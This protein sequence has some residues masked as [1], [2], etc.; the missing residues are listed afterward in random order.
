[1]IQW[2]NTIY[3]YIPIH[4]IH[5]WAIWDVIYVTFF[6]DN[7]H[8]GPNIKWSPIPKEIWANITQN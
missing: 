3:I 4:D 5:V 8:G 2:M 7:E 6:Y 1:M